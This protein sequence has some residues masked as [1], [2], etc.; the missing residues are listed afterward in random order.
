MTPGNISKRT[1]TDRLA[2]IY[3]MVDEI[4]ALPLSDRAAFFAVLS[5]LRGGVD[6]RQIRQIGTHYWL[7]N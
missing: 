2:W 1:V 3:Q 4:R 6:L 5:S 7:T